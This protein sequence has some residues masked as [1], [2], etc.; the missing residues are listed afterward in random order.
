MEKPVVFDS[1]VFVF[2]SILLVGCVP[3]VKSSSIPLELGDQKISFE[4]QQNGMNI[5]VSST[6]SRWEVT[7]DP[8]PFSLIANGDKENV[9][10]MA[11]KSVDLILPLQ[12]SSRPLVTI[13]GTGN[14]FSQND[15]YLISQPVEIYDVNTNNLQ[16]LSYFLF[17]PEKATNTVDI[18]KN[19]FT[20]F[21]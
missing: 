8:G 5:P 21:L 13:P 17:P 12:Q 11:L 1:I 16:H 10:I 18:L 7:L 14:V 15:L 19:Q 6:D 2:F 4:F 3:S 20:L 9:S